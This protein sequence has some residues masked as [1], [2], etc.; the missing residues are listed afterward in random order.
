VSEFPPLVYVDLIEDEPKTIEEFWEKWPAEVD[1]SPEATSLREEVYKTYLKRFQPWRLL[2]L[3]GGNYEPLFRSTES[4]FNR[5]DAR[6]AAELAFGNGTNV[7]LREHEKGNQIL[8][9]A[10]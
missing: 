3:S 4:Y 8:R 7:Y 10:Q 6:Y 9:M 1:D 5:E 2:I